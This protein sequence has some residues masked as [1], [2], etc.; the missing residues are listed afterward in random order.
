MINPNSISFIATNRKA[1]LFHQ[2]P[3]YI[4]RCENLAQALNNQGYRT[5]LIHIKNFSLKSA[6]RYAVFHRPSDSFKLRWIIKQ[7]KSRG[8]ITIADYDDL[9]INSDYSSFSP[10]VRNNILPIKKVRKVFNANRK[11]LKLFDLITVSTEALSNKIREISPQLRVTTIHN[12]VH[13]TWHKSSAKPI[14]NSNEKVITYFPGTRSH[15]KDFNMIAPVLESF[16]KTY[17]QIKLQITGHLNYNLDIPSSQVIKLPRVPF[18]DY[19]NHVK[20][21]WVNL[22]PLEATPFNACKSAL[23][24][25]ESGYF[26]IPTISSPNQDY[27]RLTKAGVIIASSNTEWFDTLEKLMAPKAYQELASTIRTNTLNIAD[28]SIAADKFIGAIKSDIDCTV[29]SN[30][31]VS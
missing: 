22:A 8:T 11:A 27:E 25:I 9:I 3:S 31:K 2:D 4:Y 10:A 23:K 5:E 26:G 18:S 28:A 13:Y 15:D 16:L 21:G 30:G 20:G 7:L 1:E 19:I 6:P 17:P 24:G 14:D 12:S 29:A